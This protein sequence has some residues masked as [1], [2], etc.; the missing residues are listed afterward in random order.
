LGICSYAREKKAGTKLL[1][2]GIIE[3]T[4]L[5]DQEWVHS[6]AE[7]KNLAVLARECFAF[8]FLMRENI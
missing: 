3:K 5:S 4:A 1:A 6:R 8:K 7:K 2:P